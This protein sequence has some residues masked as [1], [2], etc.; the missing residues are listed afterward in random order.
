LIGA[1][2]QI[3]ARAHEH[4]IRVYGATITPCGGSF[5]FTPQLEADRQAINKWI[6]TSGEFDGVIDFDAIT[7]D[8]ENPNHLLASVDGGDHLHPSNDGY[9]IMANDID[10]KLFSK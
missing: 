9:K 6:R 2:Q 5:Y 8:P 4:N 7:R 10:L 1:F 3:I